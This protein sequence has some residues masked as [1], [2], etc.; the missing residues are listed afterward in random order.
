MRVLVT[1]AGGQTGGIVVRKLL[2]R[3][4]AEFIPRAVVRSEASETKLRQSLGDL[5]KDLE[6]V[7]GDITQ[8]AT[9]PIVFKDIDALVVATSG[10]PRL[11]KLSLVGVIFK[12]LFTLGMM[13]AKPSF[14]FDDGQSPEEVDWVGQKNQFEAAKEAGVKHVVL[15]S[16]MAGTKP[17]HFLN[18]QMDAIV[19]WKRKAEY[20]LM[21]ESGLKY[22]II[23]PGGLLPHFGK[24]DPVPGGKRVLYAGVDDKLMDDKE[25]SLVPREDVAEV[26]MQAILNPQASQGRAFD[27][28]SGPETA[29]DHPCDIAELLEPLKGENC[30]YS[31]YDGEF[32]GIPGAKSRNCLLC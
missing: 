17:D 14:Y 5:G 26:C 4:S 7:R 21:K 10:M 23:H 24:S 19:L 18:T 8:P 32:K 29:E 25:K 3:G 13:Q 9:L 1:G 15:I 2:E 22:T 30:S 6:I 12:K 27:L 16:S 11:N 28:G 31:E 20:Y